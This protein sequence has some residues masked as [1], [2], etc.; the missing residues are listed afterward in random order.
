MPSVRYNPALYSSDEDFL[1]SELARFTVESIREQGRLH[2]PE[3]D[4]VN[5]VQCQAHYSVIMQGYI[6]DFLKNVYKSTDSKRFETSTSQTT[7]NKE[8]HFDMLPTTIWD[9]IKHKFVKMFWFKMPWIKIN[10][11]PVR[12][13]TTVNTTVVNHNTILEYWCP[14]LDLPSGH[15][16]HIL[17][18]QQAVQGL[19]IRG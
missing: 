12:N 17:F 11:T 7:E 1:K 3:M 13:I 9:H 14:H 6:I 10:Y 15:K 5:S 18:L 16:T 19:R 4:L 8:E 2:F